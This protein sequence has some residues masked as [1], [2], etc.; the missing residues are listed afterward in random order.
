VPNTRETVPPEE[1]PSRVTEARW[2]ET[3]AL[4]EADEYEDYADLVFHREAL[5]RLTFL[6]WMRQRDLAHRICFQELWR[7]KRKL[8]VVDVG[9]GRAEAFHLLCRLTERYVGLDPNPTTFGFWEPGRRA[10]FAAARGEALPLAPQVADVVLLLS[11]LDHAQDPEGVLTEV[12]RVLKP[13]GLLVLSFGNARSWLA[14]VRGWTGRAAR[15]RDEEHTFHFTQRTV[16]ALLGAS[17]FRIEKRWAFDYVRL[18]R[19]LD[20]RLPLGLLSV[21]ADTGDALGGL[22]GPRLGDSVW[23]A[24]R[25]GP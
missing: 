14:R 21:I 20:R 2:R 6:S 25:P 24:A 11:V 5:P 17:G 13:G 15:T 7:K 22:L 9:C 23:L 1:T 19:V 4:Y 8:V 18:P 10:R 3:L 16:E 12:R